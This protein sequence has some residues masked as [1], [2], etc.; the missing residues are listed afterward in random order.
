MSGG[1]LAGWAR[2]SRRALGRPQMGQ[3]RHISSLPLP[4]MCP[5]SPHP[6]HLLFLTT[7]ASSPHVPWAFTSRSVGGDVAWRGQEA[8]FSV[9]LCL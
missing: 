1:L 8:P 9:G 3:D 5:S 6:R 7:K 4:V 2:A